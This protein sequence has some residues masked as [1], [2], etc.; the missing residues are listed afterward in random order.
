M[1]KRKKAKNNQ[2]EPC[3]R[4]DCLYWQDY[5]NGYNCRMHIAFSTNCRKEKVDSYVKKE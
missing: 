2:I 4:K 3:N 1:I 5:P